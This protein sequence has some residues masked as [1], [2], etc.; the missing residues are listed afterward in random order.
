MES[1]LAE[2][3]GQLPAERRHLDQ[4]EFD[5][6]YGARPEDLARVE[7]FASDNGLE[8]VRVAADSR[9]VVLSG[10]LGRFATAFRVEL[11]W[12]PHHLGA[13]HAP[14]DPEVLP[15][16]LGEAVRGVFGLDGRPLFGT[17]LTQRDLADAD[18]LDVEE[19]G[20]ATHPLAVAE[21]YRF[22]AVEATDESIAVI[23]LGGGFYPEDMRLYFEHHGVSQPEIHVTE[24]EGQT[25][26]PAPREAIRQFLADM[27]LIDG[28]A[29]GSSAAPTAAPSTAS[30]A[31]QKKLA[32]EILWTIEATLDI[33]IT[34]LLAGIGT[35]S[36]YF[37]PNSERGKIEALAAAITDHRF[38]PSVISCSW[39]APEETLDED[40]TDCLDDLL[41]AAAL[42]GISVVYSSGDRGPDLS[43]QG[44]PRVHYPAASPFVLGCGGTILTPPFGAPEVGWVETMGRMHLASGG[45]FSRRAQRPEWQRRAAAAHGPDGR[46]V[47]D[48]A[49]K[50]DVT[51][52]W[53]MCIAGERIRMGGTSSAAPM[54]AALLA[55]L[56]ACLGSRIGWITPLLYRDAFRSALTDI[57]S[58]DNGTWACCR[59]WDPLTGLGTPRGDLLLAALGGG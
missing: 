30:A 7:A 36:V 18:G 6:L 47:P 37:A 27:G 12:H 35:V 16:E 29:E 43:E 42:R 15:P 59:G 32:T 21:H 23:L 1:A 24:L 58:G 14:E 22:P 39:G 28:R 4:E 8:V 56:N 34:A 49:A 19:Q 31:E 44:E 52:G 11:A 55:R 20:E 40:F 51:S 57:T 3:A 53:E 50:A 25:N 9:I 45:G 54:W 41:A 13:F 26:D 17:P 5:R 46:G 48:V 33:Q 10:A 38:A 2:L